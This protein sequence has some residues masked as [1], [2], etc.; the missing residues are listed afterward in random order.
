MGIYT[1]EYDRTYLGKLML[2]WIGGTLYYYPVNA[3]MYAGFQSLWGLLILR[4]KLNTKFIFGLWIFN[5]IGIGWW[6]FMFS[7]GTSKGVEVAIWSNMIIL[8]INA[9]FSFFYIFT[10]KD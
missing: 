7:Q 4:N 2:T 1:H 6:W 3:L 5:W 8:S 9:L 10:K